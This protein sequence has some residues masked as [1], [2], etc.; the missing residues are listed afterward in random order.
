MKF[1]EKVFT[2][3]LTGL[4]ILVTL[5]VLGPSIEGLNLNNIS[6][7]TSFL[8]S[9]GYYVYAE[10]GGSNVTTFIELIDTPVSY[11]GDGGKVVKVAGTEDGLEFATESGGTTNYTGLIDTPANFTGSAY[12]VPQVNAGETALE[13]AQFARSA[14]YFIAASD[15][16]SHVKTQADY[17]VIGTAEDEIQTAITAANGGTIELSKGL[18][19]ISDTIN[20]TSNTTLIGQ[21]W[22]ATRIFLANSSNVTNYAMIGYS[23]T[24]CDNCMIEGIE[25]D[26]NRTN[27]TDAS[28]GIRLHGSYNVIRDCYIHHTKGVGSAGFGINFASDNNTYNHIFRNRI[29]DTDRHSIILRD[30]G[31]DY[32][33]IKDNICVKT[34]DVTMDEQN[35]GVCILDGEHN[36]C[37][38]NFIDGAGQTTNLSFG[39]TW[40]GKYNRFINNTV[41]NVKAEPFY[42]HT[43]WTT[44][45]GN[46]VENNYGS[47]ASL[48]YSIFLEYS[49]VQDNTIV[50]P[51]E[52]MAI[53]LSGNGTIC[54]G[55]TIR[56][57]GTTAGTDRIDYG[58]DIRGDG[59]V[60][61]NNHIEGCYNNGIRAGAASANCVITDNT[62]VAGIRVAIDGNNNMTDCIISHNNIISS[63]ANPITNASGNKIYRNVGFV[64]DNSGLAE[65]V[66]LDENGVGNIAHGM[67]LTP[68]VAFVQCNNANFNIRIYSLGAT[69]ITIVVK[70]LDDVV[71]TTDTND[72]YWE[73]RYSP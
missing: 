41:V 28:D 36:L 65:N 26:G 2:V 55:N 25:L 16:P 63:N 24:T 14:T 71:V 9:H 45:I 50:A 47:G 5:A 42:D 64:T 34:E 11:T 49:I 27:Q 12:K 40:T 44:A 69:Y 37:E 39:F 62:I 22:G 54:T 67:K 18:F 23:G 1:F 53:I 61:S 10:E 70:D 56:A 8:E 19:T 57:T 7:A 6:R 52:L 30:T 43:G 59:I 66:T 15:A 31:C 13:F 29:V 58:I 68:T 72:F 32:N 35:Y 73:A 33:W 38:G 51:V 48:G 4:T 21:G 60:V 20:V 46:H 17:L 3:V